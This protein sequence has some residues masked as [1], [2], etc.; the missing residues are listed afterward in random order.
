MEKKPKDDWRLDDSIINNA[1]K[2]TDGANVSLN[3][4]ESYTVIIREHENKHHGHSHSH[5]SAFI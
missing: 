3:E 1:K 2:N 4:S 5:G